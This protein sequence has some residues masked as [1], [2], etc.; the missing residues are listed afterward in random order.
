MDVKYHHVSFKNVKITEEV[1]VN[2]LHHLGVPL[3][4]ICVPW[5]F[6]TLLET[7]PGSNQRAAEFSLAKPKTGNHLYSP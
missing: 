2:F 3:L 5:G 1:S 6:R 7:I 4:T